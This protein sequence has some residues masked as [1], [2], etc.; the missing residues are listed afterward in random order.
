MTR[1]ASLLAVG[2]LLLSVGSVGARAQPSGES[3]IGAR[4]S[5]IDRVQ[6]GDGGRC[7]NRCISGTV[8]RRCQSDYRGERENCCNLIC[9]RINNWFS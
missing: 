3:V 5:A 1:I 2:A 4:Q 7:Y 9:N 6:Y 8:F